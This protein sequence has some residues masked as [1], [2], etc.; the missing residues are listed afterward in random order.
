VRDRNPNTHKNQYP[1]S[2]PRHSHPKSLP[3]RCFTAFKFVLGVG[4]TQHQQQEIPSSIKIKKFNQCL[5]RMPTKNPAPS[6]PAT[7]PSSVSSDSIRNLP[8]KDAIQSAPQPPTQ[9]IALLPHCLP[10]VQVSIRPDVLHPPSFPAPK[11][12]PLR[13]VH[14]TP[15]P[16]PQI[17]SPQTSE[18]GTARI[19]LNKPQGSHTLNQARSQSNG[20]QN[21]TPP[22]PRRI[23]SSRE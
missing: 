23:E 10:V 15:Y 7:V 11:E 18:R 14:L 22:K 3:T 21:K 16:P 20:K 4:T 12:P 5:T 2:A 1:N 8:E 13:S 9:G 17:N 19:H 6:K